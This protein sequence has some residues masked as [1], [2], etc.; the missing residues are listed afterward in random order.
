MLPYSFLGQESQWS[1]NSG[2]HKTTIQVLAGCVEEG[3]ASKLTHV[4]GA[5]FH[6]LVGCRT[7]APDPHTL[8]AG[9]SLSSLLC[10]PLQRVDHNMEACFTRASQGE[11]PEIER[12]K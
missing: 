4:A 10:G 3:F 8:V 1:S 9:G 11:E 6:V 5:R 12:R 7:E 2:S